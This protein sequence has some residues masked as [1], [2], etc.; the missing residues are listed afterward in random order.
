MRSTDERIAAMHTR[1]AEIK[2]EQIKR[3]NMIIGSVSVLACFF[4]VIGIALAFPGL[5]RGG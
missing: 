3:R 4:V 5:T 2:R 1:A